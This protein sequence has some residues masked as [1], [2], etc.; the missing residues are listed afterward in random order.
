MA[1]AFSQ[2]VIVA[3]FF[4]GAKLRQALYEGIIIGS[5]WVMTQLLKLLIFVSVLGAIVACGRAGP[6]EPPP[7][8]AVPAENGEETPE[9]DKP[10]ILD[11]ILN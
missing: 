3:V 5:D 7:S 9:E 4:Q 1:G 6:L 2:K 11:R 8:A 10:F